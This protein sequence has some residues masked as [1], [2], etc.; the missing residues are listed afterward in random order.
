MLGEHRRA[1]VESPKLAA[2]RTATSTTD[3]SLSPAAHGVLRA[4]GGV[5]QLPLAVR[6]VLALDR[7]NERASI[8][9]LGEGAPAVLRLL[10]GLGSA[11]G[12][13]VPAALELARIVLE[14]ARRVRLVVVD[15]DVLVRRQ[16]PQEQ[17]ANRWW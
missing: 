7:L 11:D 2:G 14:A 13:R 1:V 9:S 10:L 15:V 8:E 16:E 6:R 5:P 3:L 4:C 12:E 17:K